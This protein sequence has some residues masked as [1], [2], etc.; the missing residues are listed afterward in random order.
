[1]PKWEIDEGE[2]THLRLL[3]N[4]LFCHFTDEARREARDEFLKTV[5]AVKRAH[6]RKKLCK[7]LTQPLDMH[8]LS[9]TIKYDDSRLWQDLDLTEELIAALPYFDSMCLYYIE[10]DN[11]ISQLFNGVEPI[12]IV[13]AHLETL[14]QCVRRT[15]EADL[16]TPTPHEF[17]KRIFYRAS[18]LPIDHD[19]CDKIANVLDTIEWN[20]VERI[21]RVEMTLCMTHLGVPRDI[22]SCLLQ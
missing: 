16:P 11:G 9:Y 20:C 17:L 8:M 15:V 14:P 21:Q 6:H 1:M 7:A 18:L 2:D 10:Q 22:M 12:E 4:S 13:R 5:H 19:S 3:L